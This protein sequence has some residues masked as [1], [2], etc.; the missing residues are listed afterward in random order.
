MCSGATKLQRMLLEYS[1]AASN[2]RF[3]LIENGTSVECIAPAAA[4]PAASG[5]IPITAARAASIL[6]PDPR[7][8]SGD[9]S[10]ATRPKRRCC[11]NTMSPPKARV[12]FCAKITALM[13]RSVKRSKTAEMAAEGRRTGRPAAVPRRRTAAPRRSEG[14]AAKERGCAGRR[15]YAGSAAAAARNPNPGVLEEE[16]E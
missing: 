12:S 1:T 14:D 4:P 13:A 2:T 16:E 9:E 15:G 6:M 7:N 11:V 8:P 3:V 10:S 5:Q